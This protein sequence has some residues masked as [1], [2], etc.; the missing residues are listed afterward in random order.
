MEADPREA[1]SDITSDTIKG[2]SYGHM[3][4]SKIKAIK[5]TPEKAIL[6]IMDPEK[7]EDGLFVS[8]FGCAPET[9][10]LEFQ[11]TAKKGS[12]NGNRLAYHLMQSFAP[13]DGLSPQK[14]H[15]LGME[16]AKK[17]TGGKYEFVL[18]THIDKGH[19]HNHII[20]NATSFVDRKKYH[21]GAWEKNRIRGIN[22]RICAENNLSVIEKYSGRKGKGKHEYDQFK[23]GS[24]WKDKLAKAIDAA[25]LK[26]SDFD[27]FL[28]IMELEGYEIK[29]GKHISFKLKWQGQERVTR[30]KTIGAAYTEEAI[31]ERIANKDKTIEAHKLSSRQKTKAIRPDT[32]RINLLVDISKNI[33]AQESKGYERALLKSNIDNLVKSMNYLIRHNIVTPEDFSVYEA[34][35]KADYDLTRKSIKKSE[36]NLLD[37]S[38]KIKF[39]QDYKKNKSIYKQSL[40]ENGNKEFYALHEEEILGYKTALVYF[41]KNHI[42]PE[43]L[44]LHDLFEKYKSTKE[45]R[46]RLQKE[47]IPLKN[48]YKE[49]NIVKK[50]I[51]DALGTS[52]SG[53]FDAKKKGEKNISNDSISR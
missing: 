53:T 46:N 39:T 47:F 35:I 31:K 22:D 34:G 20:F 8:S 49:M 16:F 1:A 13:E 52:L 42:S 10:A 18:T 12:Q 29:H 19:I 28:T 17:V 38:E 9:A 24:S 15:E 6:Y 36:S 26:A 25:V 23:E 30:A 44:K 3:A 7:T 50:N 43:E 5:S 37:L 11:L 32:T 33:K 4:I 14:A 45:E 40:K 51:E 41:E 2:G 21:Y 27:E 48:A